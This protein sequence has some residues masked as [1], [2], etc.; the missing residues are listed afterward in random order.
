M[1]LRAVSPLIA[2]VIL[3]SLTVSIGA[4][5][6]AWAKN[7]MNNRIACGLTHID[8]QSYTKGTNYIKFTIQ[9]T[10]E[11]KIPLN[12]TDLAVVVMDNSGNSY[13]CKLSSTLTGTCNLIKK[14]VI[15]EPGQIETVEVDFNT[16]QLSPNNVV[17]AVFIYGKCGS[18]SEQV[19][20][21]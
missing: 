4:L 9:N 3:I 5:I 18:I 20:I 19:T 11:Y 16:A 6:V 2:M 17:Q 21:S 1:A 13:T 12:S 7:Y 8:V 10:G 14:D 15:L